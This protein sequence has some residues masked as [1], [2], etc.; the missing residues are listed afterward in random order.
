MATG[1]RSPEFISLAGLGAV[2]TG[3]PQEKR[4]LHTLP[5]LLLILESFGTSEMMLILVVALIFFGPR[6]L[7]ELSRKIGKGLAEFRKA[8]ED[9][10]H[11][12]EREVAIESSHSATEPD[13]TISPPADSVM[14]ATVER[15]RAVNGPAPVQE[16][17]TQV[18]GALEPASTPSESASAA[19]GPAQPEPTRKRD[20]L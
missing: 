18:E 1:K 13:R 3:W 20:W 10:K 6:K 9:F 11:T 12:W 5:G 2:T 8:S 4:L 14:E 15:T 7:P 17:A 16:S 19:A